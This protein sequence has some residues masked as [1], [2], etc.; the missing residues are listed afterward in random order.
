MLERP[1]GKS[2]R[3]RPTIGDAPPNR[4]RAHARPAP[5]SGW[6]AN[7]ADEGAH[8]V[9]APSR[10]F[11][12]NAF[13]RLPTR[14]LDH[15]GSGVAEAI[16]CLQDC[17]SCVERLGEQRTKIRN[18]ERDV[19]IEVTAG[20]HQRLVSLPHVPGQRHVAEGHGGGGGAECAFGLK[21]WPGAVGTAGDLAVLLRAW[22]VATAARHGG[23]AEGPAR[24][25]AG[26]ERVL[27]DNVESVET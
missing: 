20:A 27:L 23:G 16:G 22:R 5:K 12:L 6:G 1:A 10:L 24:P 18:A 8:A 26:T 7:L 2:L 19:V 11:H 3:R 4:R 9:A 25:E 15:R 14:P 21:R 13:Y 17:H